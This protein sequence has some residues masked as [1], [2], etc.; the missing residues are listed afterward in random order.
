MRNLF[1]SPQPKQPTLPH[2]TPNQTPGNSELNVEKLVQIADAY[3]KIYDVFLEDNPQEPITKETFD[4]FSSLPKKEIR[5]LFRRHRKIQNYKKKYERSTSNTKDL[6]LFNQLTEVEIEE[7]YFLSI[8]VAFG[9]LSVDFFITRKMFNEYL[10]AIESHNLSNPKIKGLNYKHINFIILDDDDDKNNFFRSFERN[11]P[12]DIKLLKELFPK[13][14]LTLIHERQHTIYS[15]FK[16]DNSLLRKIFFVA[17]KN[18]IFNNMLNQVIKH[19]KIKNFMQNYVIDLLNQSNKDEL[20]S[21]LKELTKM[22]STQ[23]SDF[24]NKIQ[25]KLELS[26]DKEKDVIISYHTWLDNL[27]ISYDF[28]LTIIEKC[29]ATLQNSIRGIHLLLELNHDL[30]EIWGILLASDLSKWEEIINILLIDNSNNNRR[31]SSNIN[32]F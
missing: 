2:Q 32:N 15:F 20:L 28:F 29:N 25:T 10:K 7:E 1:K 14:Y 16:K 4:Q 22:D 30:N 11:K 6:D 17:N 26:Y 5:S 24:L 27:K 31:K 9:P 21:F 12:L 18:K 3:N 23:P 19:N 8:R 13:K